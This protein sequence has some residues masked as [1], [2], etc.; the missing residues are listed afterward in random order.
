MKKNGTENDKDDIQ[1]FQYS[2]QR[3]GY[4]IRQFQFP[5]KE[6]DHAG[7]QKRERQSLPGS[8]LESGHQN[9][10]QKNWKQRTKQQHFKPFGN[11]KRR[12]LT[13]KS[14]VYFC[15]CYYFPE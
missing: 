2:K 15:S 9:Q 6:T 8:N 1:R 11:R 7:R 3:I 4:Q 13:K 14:G 10:C 12:I 5:P